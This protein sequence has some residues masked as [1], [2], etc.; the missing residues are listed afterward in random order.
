MAA[1]VVSDV[2][3]TTLLGSTAASG[4]QMFLIGGVIFLGVAAVGYGGYR[5]YQY[6]RNRVSI[7]RRVLENLNEEEVNELV[8]QVPDWEPLDLSEN[9][10]ERVKDITL[11][12]LKEKIA[13]YACPISQQVTRE[14]VQLPCGHFFEK[15][16]II[17]VIRQKG[18]CPYCR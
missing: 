9:E 14:P 17:P 13:Y 4:I 2:G 12:K 11:E 5:L 6:Y 16:L 3:V 10:L 15:N 1:N 8:R 7:T 18:I